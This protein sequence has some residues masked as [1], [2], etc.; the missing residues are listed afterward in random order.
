MKRKALWMLSAVLLCSGSALALKSQGMFDERSEA[1][2]DY[3]NADDGGM[4]TARELRK[5]KSFYHFT[6]TRIGADLRPLQL[7]AAGCTSLGALMTAAMTLVEL[8]RRR[9]MARAA[10]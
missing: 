2:E 3:D 5:M 1:V 8:R 9:A 10:A 7:S 4:M 6:Y